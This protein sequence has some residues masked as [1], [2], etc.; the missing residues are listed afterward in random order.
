MNQ[1]N[2]WVPL[3]DKDDFWRLFNHSQNDTLIRELKDSWDGIN[4]FNFTRSVSFYKERWQMEKKENIVPQ[5][6]YR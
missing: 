2:F 5:L 3:F 6:R 1:K 4:F